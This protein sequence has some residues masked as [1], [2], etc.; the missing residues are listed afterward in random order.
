MKKVTE[1]IKNMVAKMHIPVWLAIL[2]GIVLLVRIPTFFEP[3]SYGDEMIYLTLGEGVRQG[4]TLYKDIHDNKPP[5]LYLLAAAAGN[6]FWFKAILAIWSLITITLFWHLSRALFPKKE[7]LQKVSTIIFA[8]LTTIPLL[9]GH[10]ANAEIFMIGP[11]IAAF[12]ILFTK[13]LN[14]KNIFASGVL[15]SIA[16]LFKVPAAFDVPVIVFFWLITLGVKKQNLKEILKNTFYLALGWLTP[17]ALT[18]V[19]YFA[20]G[21]LKEYLVAAFLQNIGYLS[22]WTGGVRK[23]FFIRNLPLFIRGAVLLTS[24]GLLYWKRS[25]LSKNFIFL[26][27]WLLFG[28]FAATLSQR[29]Y[30]H[31][32]LQIVPSVSFFMGMLFV[33]KTLEQSLVIIPLALTFFVPVYYKFWYY[34]SAP[35]YA[36]FIKFALGRTDKITYFAEFGGQVNRNYA[37][38]DFLVKSSRPTDKVFVWG[39]DGSAVYALSRRLPPGKYVIDYH[40]NDFFSKAEEVGVLQKNKPKFIIMLP[41]AQPFPEII[42]LLRSAYV[43]I[44]TLDGAEIWH[45]RVAEPTK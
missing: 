2:L 1:T 39:P 7:K 25:R 36:R 23:P 20:A 34:P 45:V 42:P 4:V 18:I 13:N 41:D 6:L 11:T 29:P 30:P 22:S 27:L 40:I 44:L 28:L 37:L 31:Y 24:T 26:T 9:E 32:L 19:W 21:G 17:I 5:L 10:I 12:L 15:F 3:F 8:I 14:F 35:Y 16:T 38:A 43:P 33:D